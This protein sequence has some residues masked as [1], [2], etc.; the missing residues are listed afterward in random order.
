MFKYICIRCGCGHGS[1]DHPNLCSVCYGMTV[2]CKFMAWQENM[3]WDINVVQ[4]PYQN[5]DKFDFAVRQRAIFVA[6]GSTREEALNVL[7]EKI[8]MALIEK[9]HDYQAVVSYQL[10]DDSEC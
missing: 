7:T 8:S 5:S 9:A 10:V 4:L 6:Y 3:G 2:Y 1:E